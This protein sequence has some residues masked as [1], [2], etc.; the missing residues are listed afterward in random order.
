MK[1]HLPIAL[2][3]FLCVSALAGNLT[4]TANIF[5]PD[6]SKVSAVIENLPI[7]IETSLETPPGGIKPYADARVERLTQRGFLIVLTT[8][9]RA[10]R[11]SMNPIGIASSEGV[12][13]AGDQMVAKFKRGKFSE[14]AIGLTQELVRLSEL[15]KAQVEAPMKTVGSGFK[16]VG[17]IAASVSAICGVFVLVMI[18]SIVALFL[19]R[20]SE[21]KSEAMR[22]QRQKQTIPK[23]PSPEE[24]RRVF[25]AYTPAQRNAI[26]EEHHHHH[27]SSGAST[28]PLL[29]WML[30]NNSQ[31]FYS[32]LAPSYA[33]APVYEAPRQHSPSP[34]PDRSSSSSDSGSSFDFGGSSDVGGSFSDSSGGGGSW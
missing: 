2:L 8:Q 12:R 27:Y 22:Q 28:D 7:W 14:G 32:A 33:P 24:A 6:A 10:W 15:P 5:G 25:D 11:V 23:S 29:F 26:I 9:P 1:S 30:M 19:N 17:W 21:R 34:E 20:R 4:D 18:V 3:A 31:P 16:I 13:L